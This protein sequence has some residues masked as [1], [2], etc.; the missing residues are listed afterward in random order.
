M[1]PPLEKSVSFHMINTILANDK[2][3]VLYYFKIGTTSL[4]LINSLFKII[5]PIFSDQK[6]YIL[7]I[8]HNYNE[9]NAP[10]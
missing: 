2:L 3:N 4:L 5:F 9:N 7:Y 8:V 6:V 1:P 10:K